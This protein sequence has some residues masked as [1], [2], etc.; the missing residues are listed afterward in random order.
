MNSRTT[1]S[2]R[3][4]IDGL[5]AIAIISVLLY[6]AFPEYFK[7]GFV[8]VDIFFVISGYLITS[9]ILNQLGDSSFSFKLFYINRIVRLFPALMTVMFFTVII[10]YFVLLPQEFTQLGKN[11][12]Y[13]TGFVGNIGFYNEVGYFDRASETKQL[14]HLWSLGVEEQ[15][16]II[17]PFFLWI[18]WK[19]K[20][21]FIPAVL[22]T[23]ILISFNINIKH[24]SFDQEYSFFL[25]QSRFWEILSGGLIGWIEVKKGYLKNSHILTIIS[26]LGVTLIIISFIFVNS[27]G[28][29]PGFLALLPVTG[30]GLLIVSKDSWFNSSVLS[31][32]FLI[33]IG[34]IS[35]PL[36]LW[37]WPLLSFSYVINNGNTPKLV[38]GVLVIVALVLSIATFK[39]IEK[40][41]KVQTY[42]SKVNVT[43]ILVCGIVLIGVVGYIAHKSIINPYASRFGVEKISEAVNDWG[44]PGRLQQK[45]YE[46]GDQIWLQGSAPYKVLLI[47]D[48]NIQQYYPRIEKLMNSSSVPFGIKFVTGGGCPPFPQV[49]QDGKYSYCGKWIDN[50]YKIAESEE[51][52]N[53]I[54]GA[55]WN[56][57]MLKHQQNYITDHNNNKYLINDMSTG[58]KL[59]LKKLQEKIAYLVSL[60]KRVYVILNIPTGIE[61]A[62]SSQI[63]RSIS[64]QPVKIRHQVTTRQKFVGNNQQYFAD[65]RQI[66]L[67]AGAIVIDPL[68]YIC[69]APTYICRVFSEDGRPIYK[70]DSHLRPFYVKDY[71][72]YVDEVL[73][74][75]YV[76]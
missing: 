34:L 22:V 8:G 21:Y 14:L 3:P 17:W 5:R 64:F 72:T 39:L 7:S 50:G 6:H 26:G 49:K 51:I 48:S 69:P 38:R 25:P 18:T 67:D 71:L 23:L 36:Y 24:I 46:N 47:G 57:Y 53:V 27:P 66:A 56:S 33:F 59:A 20:P 52:N 29:F 10:G 15:F 44:F 31:N 65:L 19:I 1:G 74:G 32:R 55:M 12:F 75:I 42:I 62:P 30:S 16:Y 73:T 68:D 60:N 4:D 61:F 45:V 35:Y 54:I 2:Y 37:H 41:I 28:N 40:K 9:I 58:Y 43:V 76:K 13:S 70:D 11:L 63:L